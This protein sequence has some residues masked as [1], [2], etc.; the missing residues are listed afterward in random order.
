MRRLRSRRFR[1]WEADFVYIKK[2]EE[3]RDEVAAQEDDGE[4]RDKYLMVRKCHSNDG[5]SSLDELRLS[6][7][8]CVFASVRVCVCDLHASSLYTEL[9]C[10]ATMAHH[11][12]Y[13]HLSRY[14]KSTAVPTVIRIFVFL[15]FTFVCI[16][17]TLWARIGSAELYLSKRRCWAAQNPE[18]RK[19]KTRAQGCFYDSTNSKKTT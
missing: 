11:Q 1:K 12:H 2:H 18:E 10:W 13:C 8:Y 3:R 9:S 16:F 6:S 5:G 7:H 4:Q 14:A 19:K 17:V 15:F